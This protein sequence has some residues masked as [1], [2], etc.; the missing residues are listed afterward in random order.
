MDLKSE[1]VRGLA[2]LGASS[3]STSVTYGPNRPLLATIM[4]VG[5]RVVAEHPLLARGVR[6]QLARL[7]EGE[8]VRRQ[9]LGDVGPGSVGGLDVRP[10]APDSQGDAV[11]ELECGQL[12]GVDLA[13][14]A[15]DASSARP[16]SVATEVELGQL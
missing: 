5:G 1:P 3:S 9:V 4:R 2:L 6:E 10:V 16:A 12:A 14:L 13:E 11:A 8:L 7:V 15:D